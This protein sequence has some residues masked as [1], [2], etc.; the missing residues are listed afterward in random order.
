VCSLGALR[1]TGEVPDDDFAPP[2]NELAASAE[3]S[4]YEGQLTEEQEALLN[5]INQAVWNRVRHLFEF[6]D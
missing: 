1:G 3:T 5:D 6:P 2:E 4:G